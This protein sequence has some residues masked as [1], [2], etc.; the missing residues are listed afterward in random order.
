M[1]ESHIEIKSFIHARKYVG[2]SLTSVFK[3][4]SQIEKKTL[5][6]LFN[7]KIWLYHSYSCKHSIKI[8]I[9]ST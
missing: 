7:F 8:R 4:I 9:K 5:E 3:R 1:G 2:I 6:I